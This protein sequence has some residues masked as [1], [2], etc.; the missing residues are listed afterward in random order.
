[1]FFKGGGGE[2]RSWFAFNGSI[3]FID[4]VHFLGKCVVKI[5]FDVQKKAGKYLTSKKK[6]FNLHKYFLKLFNI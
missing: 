6:N 5:I 3:I 2:G 1:M 4:C